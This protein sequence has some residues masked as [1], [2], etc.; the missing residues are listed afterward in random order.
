MML[1]LRSARRQRCA[2][3]Y[4]YHQRGASA[5]KMLRAARGVAL[6]REAAR[7]KDVAMARELTHAAIMLRR[8][9][10]AAPRPAPR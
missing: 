4:T 7:G 9:D 2:W 8:G 6:A 3:R 1:M 10:H 5:M